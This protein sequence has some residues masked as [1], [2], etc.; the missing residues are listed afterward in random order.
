MMDSVV[1]QMLYPAPPVRVASPPP[2]PLVEVPL[3][4]NGRAVSAWYRPP[5]GESA[6][7]PVVLMLHGNGE[8]LET[9]RQSGLFAD[10]AAAGAGVLAIDYP[11][12]GRSPGT[13]S[14]SA[15][16]AAAEAAWSWLLRNAN[17]HPPV[18]AG[19]S[20]GAAVAA[21][22]AARHQ[23]EPAGVMLLSSWDRLDAVARLHFP[24]WMVGAL[25][26]E[27]YDSAEAAK[28]I[29]AP[30]LLIH[31]DHD[32]I[33]PIALGRSLYA[34]LPA[35]KQWIEIRGAGHNDLLAR[36][37]AWH[38]INSFLAEIGSAPSSSEKPGR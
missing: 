11:G 10:F 20:L 15:N 13:P 19:W 36:P 32:T 18:L 33:I 30:V 22:L 6:T 9:M 23:D 16:L 27:R 12:Y 34:A 25:L 31:G 29:T 1:R 2:A 28:T 14:E 5:T 38:A 17:G 37:E 24:G 3:E 26:S 8:N 21:Q 4:A 7:A 35:E